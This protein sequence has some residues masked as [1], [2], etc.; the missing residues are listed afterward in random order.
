M[1][2]VVKIIG[3]IFCVTVLVCGCS[4][5]TENPKEDS[6]FTEDLLAK[7]YD[8]PDAS[9]EQLPDWYGLEYEPMGDWPDGYKNYGFS[10]EK[11]QERDIRNVS[12]LGFNFLR[13]PVNTRFFYEDA[14][15]AKAREEYWNNLDELI[16][17][18]IQYQ[19][20][21]SL[22][23]CE[24]YG[25]NCT[26]T[27]AEGELFT[28][29]AY[30]ELFLTFWEEIARRYQDVPNNALSFNILNEPTDW[31]GEEQYCELA[32]NAVDRIRDCSPDRLIISDMFA[33]GTQPLYG[34]VESG[35]VQAVHW[36]RPY[37]LTNGASGASWPYTAP[38]LKSHIEGLDSITLRG[39]FEVGTE[40]LLALRGSTVPNSIIASVDGREIPIAEFSDPVVGKDG[41]AFIV[42]DENSQARYANYDII[43][44][45][46]TLDSDSD[47]IVFH[48][49]DK[50]GAF[51]LDRIVVHQPGSDEV[52][53]PVTDLDEDIA[54]ALPATD[55]TIS[56]SGIVTD[57][58]S[59][60]GYTSY[61][62]DWLRES[63]KPYADFAAETGTA[64]FL[65]EF[66]SS[67]TT[68]YNAVL[69]YIDDMLTVTDEYGWSWSMYDYIGDFGLVKGTNP[70]N[71]REGA[72]YETIGDYQVDMGLYDVLKQHFR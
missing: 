63:L 66:G 70:A 67:V 24:T 15:I 8:M 9:Y 64:V 5:N 44:A 55:L 30:M 12:E 22:V 40:I 1:K 43:H 19:V 57:N 39:P 47:V 13:V 23:V 18:G 2:N 56:G 46:L 53:I 27:E 17:W 32:L 34:L 16:A 4:K 29:D 50:Y 31:I 21:I 7:A 41:C 61:D 48:S 10:S 14:D 36:Y 68:D 11:F 42:Y 38:Y 52:M 60:N 54:L 71:V 37:E 26:Y 3:L 20:H 62:I 49:L 59:A 58:V 65:N 45:A 51:D 6:L 28:N 35:I 33:W 72:V 25:Y 69:Y